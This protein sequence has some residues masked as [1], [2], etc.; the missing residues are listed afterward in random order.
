MGKRKQ[1]TRWS[2]V[3]GIAWSTEDKQENPGEAGVNA[4]PTRNWVSS[5]APRF[6]R[7]A[8]AEAEQRQVYYEGEICEAEELPNG[9]TKIRSKNLDVLFKRDYYEQRLVV[10]QQISEELNKLQECDYGEDYCTI[11]DTPTSSEETKTSEEPK[12]P[13]MESDN[14][15]KSRPSSFDQMDPNEVPEFKPLDSAVDPTSADLPSGQTSPIYVNHLPQEYD[16]PMRPNL[17][18]YSP[19]NNTLIPCEEIIIPNPVMSADGPIHP[20]PTNIYLAYPVQGPAGRGYIT[21]PFNSPCY[22][23]PFSPGTS[24]EGSSCFASTP[25]TPNTGHESDTSPLAATPPPPLSYNPTTWTEAMHYSQ[26]QYYDAQPHENMQEKILK[27]NIPKPG[28]KSAKEEEESTRAPVNY[29]PGLAM[30]SMQNAGK[31]KRKKKAKAGNKEEKCEVEKIENESCDFELLDEIKTVANET[32]EMIQQDDIANI[33][34]SMKE[35]QLTDDL[36]NSLINP[37]TDSESLD[38]IEMEN[39]LQETIPNLEV[40]EKNE[41]TCEI[42]IKPCSV[43]ENLIEDRE[44]SLIMRNKEANTEQVTVEVNES[45][46]KENSPEIKPALKKS[47][48]YVNVV[49]KT[50][51]SKTQTD[52][53]VTRNNNEK[54]QNQEGVP[55]VAPKNVKNKNSKKNKKSESISIPQVS[56]V[57]EVEVKQSYSSIIKTNLSN[58]PVKTK[59]VESKKVTAPAPQA[60]SSQQPENPIKETKNNRVEDEEKWENI[61][62][63]ISKPE[64]WENTSKKRKSKKKNARFAEN[65]EIVKP[66]SAADIDTSIKAVPE[67]KETTPSIEE[68]EQEKEKENVTQDQEEKKARRKKKKA[69]STEMEDGNKVRR[70]I[71]CD[72]QISL[73]H[74]RPTRGADMIVPSSLMEAVKDSLMVSQLGLGMARGCMDYGRLYQGKYV[75][76][77]RTDGMKESGEIEGEEGEEEENIEQKI[78]D[79]ET[80]RTGDIDLD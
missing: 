76:P 45:V 25:Q 17:Y 16:A 13:K 55:K 43:D 8:A 69:D 39:S 35:I 75:P 38:N 60:V 59:K 80:S 34:A 44:V 56:S 5:V 12:E 61:P 48:S 29:I 54:S 58:E 18:L 78:E 62:E 32:M 57:P 64:T 7:K 41:G 9:F 63:N 51:A 46:M 20:G 10:Q 53:T 50:D 70:I 73:E 22:S 52:N 49:R 4:K 27:L 2:S 28:V 68:S 30:D 11:E 26:P 14:T 74:M 66:Q 1:K 37:P 71:I 19:A 23:A 65:V 6:E 33:K 21:Q 40:V 42:D 67:T 24:Y 79:L 3:E 47:E 31:K 77:E 36:A 15:N 72:E